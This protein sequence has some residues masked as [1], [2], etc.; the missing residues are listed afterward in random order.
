MNKAAPQQTW[1]LLVHWLVDYMLQHGISFEEIKEA[2]GCDVSDP[3]HCFLLI[4]DYLSLL[5]WSAKRLSAPHLG[6]DVAD[7]V[8]PETFGILGYLL[9]NS[10][11]VATLCDMVTRYQPLFMRGMKFSFRQYDELFEIQWEI[12]R[13]PSE[14]VR[15][16]VEFSLAA[17]LQ[18]IR[19]GLGES[20]FPLKTR[21]S[22][23]CV[24]P[25]A[26]YQKTFGPDVSFEQEKN[27][28]IFSAD[29]LEMPLNESDPVLL[30]ILKNQADVMLQEWQDTESFV[31][32][33]RLHIATSLEEENAGAETVAN[34]LHITTRTLNRQL[35]REGTN[36][37]RLREEVIVE[38]AMQ[39]LA[40]SDASVTAIG[41]KLGYSESSAFVRAFKRMTGTTPVAYRKQARLG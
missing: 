5:G 9:R 39:S 35:Q 7:Q 34:R 8:Q 18:T 36:Y 29:V 41:G 2:V 17:F 15:Q 16:D 14:S 11:N 31:G 38:L 23:P 28:I 25:I 13:S 3:A 26:R 24:E 4:D 10:R 20:I 33:A 37:Q 40:E 21:I 32:Q 1:G 19:V 6:L 12:F 30:D 22:H 27:C